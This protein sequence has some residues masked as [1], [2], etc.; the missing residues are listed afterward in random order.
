M[1]TLIF[2]LLF[3]AT[4]VFSKGVEPL[5]PEVITPLEV[6]KIFE[7]Q[8]IIPT[9]KLIDIVDREEKVSACIEDYVKK[10]SKSYAKIV[11]NNLYDLVHN[12]DRIASKIYGK[13]P[14]AD[15]I[16]YEEKVVAL[17]KLQ[18]EAY[19]TMKVIK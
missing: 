2:L 16:S 3:V 15:E 17:A 8:Y 9:G 14:G 7:E 6:H 18:C 12:F 13:K 1:R 19:Y 5:P 4:N 10:Q 11:Q